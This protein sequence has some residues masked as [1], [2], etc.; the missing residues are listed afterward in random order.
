MIRHESTYNKQTGL[1][2]SFTEYL[3]GKLNYH[4]IYDDKQRVIEHKDNVYTLKRKLNENGDII[5]YQD[6]LGS[7]I[8]IIESRTKKVEITCIALFGT[9][10]N[11]IPLLKALRDY[12]L[13]DGAGTKHHKLTIRIK[14]NLGRL[15]LETTSYKPN[16]SNDFFLS[17]YIENHFYDD[18][19]TQINLTTYPK[20]LPNLDSYTCY[21]RLTPLDYSKPSQTNIDL[22]EF[23]KKA[24]FLDLLKNYGVYY[25]HTGMPL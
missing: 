25:T 19:T 16:H 7:F 4:Q 1:L 3:N 21:H 13:D 11:S 9:F 5:Q 15:L 14:D 18:Y 20:K 2:T 10:S 6:T 17:Q 12:K 23:V 22:K 24:N 8:N